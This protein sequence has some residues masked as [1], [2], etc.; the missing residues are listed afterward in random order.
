MNKIILFHE[1]FVLV[2]FRE[3]QSERERRRDVDMNEHQKQEDATS[4]SWERIS[5]WP[6][7]A[8]QWRSTTESFLLFLNSPFRSFV[9]DDVKKKKYL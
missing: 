8:R 6:G 1:R 3:Q 7:G 9:N 5:G 2:E 4:S